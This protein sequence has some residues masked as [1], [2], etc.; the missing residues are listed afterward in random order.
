MTYNVGDKHVFYMPSHLMVALLVAPGI[1]LIGDI[2]AR[3]ETFVQNA[4]ARVALKRLA[5]PVVALALIWY[6]AVRIHRDYP[7]LDRS[8]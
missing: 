2:A 7:A 4:Q 1:V 6:C 3:T 8:A 5:G